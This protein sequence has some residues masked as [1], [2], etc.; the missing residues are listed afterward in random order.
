[1]IKYPINSKSI[2]TDVTVKEHEKSGYLSII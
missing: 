2:V 1:M